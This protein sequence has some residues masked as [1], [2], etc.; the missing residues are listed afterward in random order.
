[1]HD[2][3]CRRSQSLTDHKDEVSK[4]DNRKVASALVSMTSIKLPLMDCFI[5][6]QW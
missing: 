4:R 6:A 2:Y 1:M 3:Y 5:V